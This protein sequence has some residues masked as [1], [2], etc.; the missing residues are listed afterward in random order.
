MK[1]PPRFIA[2]LSFALIAAGAGAGAARAGDWYAAPGAGAGGTGT[3]EAPWEL[4]QALS[5]AQ[6]A[7]QPGDTLWLMEGSYRPEVRDEK[8]AQNYAIGLAGA[9]GRRAVRT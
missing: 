8:A 2:S 3:R 9:P 6:E 5:G 4:G 1:V 7:I